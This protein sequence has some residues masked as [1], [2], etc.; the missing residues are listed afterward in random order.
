MTVRCTSCG[1]TFKKSDPPIIIDGMKYHM[2]CTDELGLLSNDEDTD[3]LDG[4]TPVIV[5]ISEEETP[6]LAVESVEGPVEDADEDADEDPDDTGYDDPEDAQYVCPSCHRVIDGS[7]EEIMTFRANVRICNECSEK[8]DGPALAEE[9]KE[10]SVEGPSEEPMEE[11]VEEPK[12]EPVMTKI[13]IQEPPEKPKSE[14]VS[15]PIQEPAREPE[16]ASDDSDDKDE[17]YYEAKIKFEQMLNLMGPAT[18]IEQYN[19]HKKQSADVRQTGFGMLDRKTVIRMEDAYDRAFKDHFDENQDAYGDYVASEDGTYITKA[20]A[21]KIQKKDLMKRK[22]NL[23]IIG[24]GKKSEEK[25]KEGSEEAEQEPSEE[26]D[27]EEKGWK[28]LKPRVR[29]KK[30]EN[31]G[32]PDPDSLSEK[33][34]RFKLVHFG[35]YVILKTL[36]RDD[37]KVEYTLETT[38]IPRSELPEDAVKVTGE[39]NTYCLDKIKKSQWYA[40]SRAELMITQNYKQRQFNASDAALYMTTNKIDNALAVKWLSKYDEDDRK[41]WM[42]LLAAIG[43]IAVLVVIILRMML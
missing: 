30:K 2:E 29:T 38:L 35:G 11:P 21:E 4:E 8:D 42:V 41:K 37:R 19:H 12:E 18:V 40:E 43:V 17:Y 23:G 24:I 10:E 31:A 32:N 26:K 25:P 6:A 27:E 13:I 33:W 34:R 1:K 22:L 3:E 36:T 16:R 5:D 20:Q 14:P 39:N 28:K 7:T 9:P 15:I